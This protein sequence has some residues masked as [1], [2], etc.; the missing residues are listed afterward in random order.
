[1]LQPINIS[2]IYCV[3]REHMSKV[4]H[5]HFLLQSLDNQ[6]EDGRKLF[7][8]GKVHFRLN[9]PVT[10]FSTHCLA[11]YFQLSM[12]SDCD[13]FLNTFFCDKHTFWTSFY[14]LKLLFF[15]SLYNLT[16]ESY[17]CTP[18]HLCLRADLWTKTFL[19]KSCHSIL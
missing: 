12:K 15:H 1:M 7:P 10:C 4:Y 2:L 9:A 13:A 6:W 17:Y 16:H 18:V 8:V 11:L 19:P 3:A 14:P 5:S